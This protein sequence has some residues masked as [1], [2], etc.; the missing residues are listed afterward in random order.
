[1]DLHSRIESISI[2]QQDRITWR[3]T[4]NLTISSIYEDIRSRN[5]APPWAKAIW[6]AFS[7]PKCSFFMWLA[8]RNRL[9]TKD[10]MRNFGMA[11]NVACVLCNGGTVESIDHLMY[12]CS[13]TK[14]VFDSNIIQMV[15][16]WNLYKQGCLFNN[17]VYKFHELMALLYLS[18]VGHSI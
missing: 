17:H 4:G 16:D 2:G 12:G 14:P 11:V 13:S 10:R 7:I 3:G 6:H 8:F 9:L 18:V 15:G 1:M 5:T